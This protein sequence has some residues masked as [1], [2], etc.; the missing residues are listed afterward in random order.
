MFIVSRKIEIVKIIIQLQAIKSK[1]KVENPE[2]GCDVQLRRGTKTK[3]CSTNNIQ[4][5]IDWVYYR[6]YG[7]PFKIALPKKKIILRSE[8]LFGRIS[9]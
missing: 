3:I 9:C 8:A 1:T 6:V 5:F 7:K 2:H 4:R